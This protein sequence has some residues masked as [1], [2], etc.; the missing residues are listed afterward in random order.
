MCGLAP[1]LFVHLVN[2]ER[3]YL[4]RF[5][6][7]EQEGQ[8]RGLVWEDADD[9]LSDRCPHR[10]DECGTVDPG[11]SESDQECEVDCVEEHYASGGALRD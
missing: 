6:R 8:N 11:E 7:V 2:G 4:V 9:E 3:D 1:S 5:Q 10:G